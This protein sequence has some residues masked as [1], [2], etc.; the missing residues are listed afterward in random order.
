MKI[1]YEGRGFEITDRDSKNVIA[2]LEYWTGL[3]EDDKNKLKKLLLG[4][5]GAATYFAII[6]TL[7]MR[8]ET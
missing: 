7:L 3:P 4:C 2:F 6:Y 5:M 8:R 1:K